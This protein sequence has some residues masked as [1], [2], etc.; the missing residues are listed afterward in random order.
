MSLQNTSRSI[1]DLLYNLGSSLEKFKGVNGLQRLVTT[2]K[3]SLLSLF[4]EFERTKDEVYERR[5]TAVNETRRCLIQIADEFDGIS[6][7]TQK[8][9]S[10][11]DHL[12]STLEY[13]HSTC[14]MELD[15]RSTA[16]DADAQ[17]L[18]RDLA[19]MHEKNNQFKKSLHDFC[20]ATSTCADLTRSAVVQL[21]EVDT[22]TS[23]DVSVALTDFDRQRRR[24]QVKENE[25][26]NA[27]SKASTRQDP[28]VQFAEFNYLKE[29]EALEG[30]GKR[31]I[32]SLAA[33]MA[34][35]TFALEQ[36]S[37]TGW[38]SSNVFFVQLGLFLHE[39]MEGSKAV[40][41]NLLSVKN[42]Q[43]VSRQLT[44]E[45]HH[46]MQQQRAAVGNSYA[47]AV[48]ALQGNPAGGAPPTAAA[49][50]RVCPPSSAS[51]PEQTAAAARPASHYQ[52]PSPSPSSPAAS[53]SVDLDDLFQ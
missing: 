50:P 25:V 31:Y 34:A 39:M 26:T 20:S 32:D 19:E 1:E 29:S 7:T 13:F 30:Y 49:S 15:D 18:L 38:A 21:E 51:V 35:T 43:K 42:A 52:D 12:F 53:K 3:L 37:M 4:G 28:A 45:K 8:L 5:A 24:V 17:Q 48:D 36:S 2:G 41:A 14:D 10:K 27:M 23:Y 46:L 9:V 47:S 40:A 16:V 22:S 33:A 6:G 44:A 11:L